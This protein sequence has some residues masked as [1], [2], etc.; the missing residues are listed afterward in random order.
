MTDGNHTCMQCGTTW[1]NLT[2]LKTELTFCTAD[3]A[4][5]W[6]EA[7]PEEKKRHGWLTRQDLVVRMVECGVLKPRGERAKS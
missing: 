5:A 2:R 3:C 6:M 1:Y 4:D 7:N